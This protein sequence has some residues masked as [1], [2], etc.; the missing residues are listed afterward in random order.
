[1]NLLREKLSKSPVH[2]RVV[3]YVLI[4]VITTLLQD[5]FGEEARYWIYLGKMLFGL[6]CIWEMRTLVPEMRWAISWEAVAVGVGVCVIWI[7]LDPY[8]PKN[9]LMMKQGAPW[10]PFKAFG[11]GSEMGW[12][13]VAVRTLGSAIIIPPIEEAFYRSFLYRYCVRTDFEAMPL[14]RFH[15]TSFLVISALFGFVHFQWLP[16][17]LCGFAFQWLVIRKN[18]LG[19]A[20]TAHAITNF[21]LGVWIAWQ[22]GDEFRF[23]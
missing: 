11:A 4:L 22:G 1:M 9:E 6:L 21:L 13:F 12:L 8:Y 20:I 10:N 2:A 23:W 19:D 16:G 18:R 3:P 7:G 5:S 15:P 17:I 14:S